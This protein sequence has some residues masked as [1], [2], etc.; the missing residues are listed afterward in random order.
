MPRRCV[1]RLLQV[2]DLQLD[3]H[4]LR[5]TLYSA[6]LHMAGGRLLLRHHTESSTSLLPLVRRTDIEAD[7]LPLA[8]SVG[9][10]T[11]P[12]SLIKLATATSSGRSS[13]NQSK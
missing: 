4:L 9:C 13:F 10:A 2:A 8:T 12:A 7:S 6:P 5:A 1:N 11:P 3:I